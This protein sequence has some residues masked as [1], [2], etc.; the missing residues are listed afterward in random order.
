MGV[1]RSSHRI[2]VENSERKR[3]I[4]K[5]RSRLQIAIKTDLRENG[6]AMWTGLIWLRRQTSG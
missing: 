1:K 5:P 6:R 4:E 3:Q 2:F